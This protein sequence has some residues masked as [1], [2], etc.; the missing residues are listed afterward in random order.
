MVYWINSLMYWINSLMYWIHPNS[1]PNPN[2]D[3]KF[4]PN[5]KTA[6]LKN[7]T[8][9]KPP[10]LVLLHSKMRAGTQNQAFW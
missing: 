8:G 9:W 1:S 2:P 5:T 10:V 7:Q 3:S 4:S 6:N